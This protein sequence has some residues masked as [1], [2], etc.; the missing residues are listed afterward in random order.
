MLLRYIIQTRGSGLAWL[1][2][3]LGDINRDISCCVDDIL[4][5]DQGMGLFQSMED[6]GLQVQ[7]IL[8][9]MAMPVQIGEI[10]LVPNL[11]HFVTDCFIIFTH[12]I[13]ITVGVNITG[14]CIYNLILRLNF[15]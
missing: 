12:N 9:I 15:I 2:L 5:G 13:D 8:H 7:Y 3:V 4:S 6:E 14:L 11:C 10:R 1:D